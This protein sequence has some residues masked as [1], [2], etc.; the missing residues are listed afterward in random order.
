MSPVVET[1]LNAEHGLIFEI[2][3]SIYTSV[4]QKTEVTLIFHKTARAKNCE[5]FR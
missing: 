3:L 2:V 1:P 4:L 5:N